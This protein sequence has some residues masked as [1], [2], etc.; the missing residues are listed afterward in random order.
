MRGIHVCSAAGMIG[1]ACLLSL[2]ACTLPDQQERLGTRGRFTLVILDAATGQ[3]VPARVEL[4]D[5][6][7]KGHVAHDALPIL[8]SG[9]LSGGNV[10]SKFRVTR[11]FP[12]PQ[13]GTD[14]F[15]STGRSSLPLSPGSYELSIWKGPEY[16]TVRARLQ[17]AAG[18]RLE[19]EVELPR[20]TD[21][22]KHGWYSADDHIH[23]PR[24][25]SE[26]NASLHQWMAAEDIHVANLLQMGSSTT[27][28]FAPQYAFGAEGHDGSDHH[29]LVSG[30]ENPR[31]HFLGHTI[32][33]GNDSPIHY[34][35][36]YLNF[37]KFFAEGRRQG[38]LNGFAHFGR[39]AGGQLGLSFVLP[40]KLLDFLEILQYEK[41]RYDIWY[42]IL[43]TGFRLTPTAGTDYPWGYSHPG[44]E[45]FYTRV[46]DGF[47]VD[48]WIAAVRAG[49]TFVT[50]GP[51]LGFRVNGEEMGGSLEIAQPGTVEIDAS[52]FFDPHRDSIDELELIENGIVVRA[53]PAGGRESDHILCHFPHDIRESGWLAVRVAGDKRG[54]APVRESLAH[55]APIYVTVA[56][57]PPLAAKGEARRMARSWIA[58]LDDLEA[59]LSDQNIDRL[60]RRVASAPLDAETIRQNRPYL[61]GA[62][63][64]A[65]TH[66]REQS[67]Q[68][69]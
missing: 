32:I 26:A 18:Q 64:E 23:L 65:R 27:F 60:A 35:D 25:T 6:T 19:H 68:L 29:V 69:P 9:P 17:I 1:L 46:D 2:P 3:P 47:T 5:E 14:Q 59:G 38:A 49:R 63:Q 50:N 52:V 62:I 67:R 56:N 10:R 28:D 61:L 30:Q 34:P 42:K 33:L 31:T 13:T 53:C 15:Y 55:S 37:E 21:M 45:R 22:P 16:R 48:K 57:A 4:L 7:G 36:E 40:H 39:S 66:F 41:G 54:E 51:M 43:N 8:V 44:R 12:N 58:I 24:P 20:W 11:R